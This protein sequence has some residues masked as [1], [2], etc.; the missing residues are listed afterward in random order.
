MP[1]P[2]VYSA[3]KWYGVIKCVFINEI[4]ILWQLCL[5]T[6][7]KILVLDSDILYFHLQCIIQ[8]TYI[9]MV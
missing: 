1:L 3:K 7:K 2:V 4:N 8:Y 9:R 5:K 6:E